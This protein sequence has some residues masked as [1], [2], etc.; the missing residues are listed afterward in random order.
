MIRKETSFRITKFKGKAISIAVC[1]MFGTMVSG[2]AIAVQNVADGVVVVITAGESPNFTGA[3]GVLTGIATVANGQTMVGATNATASTAGVGTI[4][5]AQGATVD[6][7]ATGTTTNRIGLI[8]TSGT[9]LGTVTFNTDVFAGALTIANSGTAVFK[10]LGAAAAVSGGITNNL[11]T[12]GGAFTVSGGDAIAGT[13]VGGAVTA[14]TVGGTTTLAALTVTG[15]AGGTSAAAG[16]VGGAVTDATFTG[17]VTATTITLGGGAGGAGE[18]NTV[19]VGGAGGALTAAT[20]SGA[21]TG[22]VTMTGGLGGAGAAG[23]AAGALTLGVGGAGGAATLANIA[24]IMDN[25]RP[26]G[27]V[28][29]ATW[30]RVL[31]VNLTGVMRLS[32]AALPVMIAQGGGVMVTVASKAALGAGASGIAYT[33]SKHAVIG[34]VKSTAYFYGTQ[35]IR[36]NAVLPGPVDTNIGT[37]SAPHSEWAMQRAS[38]SMATLT[39]SAEPDQIASVISWLACDEASNLNG[40]VV[41]A[42]GGWASA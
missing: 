12:T 39:K 4:T 7:N 25:F 41:S 29:D 18:A 17:A 20:F 5:F 3:A 33:S 34:L 15:G 6:T 21:V 23:G 36:S 22:N 10:A 37:T 8:T 40:S 13:G 9:T 24:G 35:G 19:Q 30:D 14:F 26:L 1:A 28:D 27:E 32:R 42:D 2:A 31:D 38:L 16:R 11:G